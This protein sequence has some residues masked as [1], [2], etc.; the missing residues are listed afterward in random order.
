MRTKRTKDEALAEIARI[1]DVARVLAGDYRTR[2][3]LHSAHEA[4]GYIWARH[5]MLWSL[6]KR[7]AGYGAK[8]TLAAIEITAVATQM[9]RSCYNMREVDFLEAAAAE[10]TRAVAKHGIF[11]SAHEGCSVILEEIDELWDEVKARNHLAAIDEL[12]QVGAMGI[13]YAA[14]LCDSSE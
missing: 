8:A 2:P 13:K 12:I 7:D 11:A 3:A 1:V 5:E 9:A 14:G 10:V 6:V 4:M